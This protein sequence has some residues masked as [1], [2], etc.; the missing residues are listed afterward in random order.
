MTC[1]QA[2]L[3]SMK[4]QT[5][6]AVVAVSIFPAGC[7][8]KSGSSGASSS[9]G[10]EQAGAASAAITAWEQG[11]KST[12]ISSFVGA[13]WTARPLFSSSSASSLS[14]AQFRALPEAARQAKSNGML[15][16]LDVLK[17]LA[18]AAVLAGHTLQPTALVHE[19]YLRLVGPEQRKSRSRRHSVA[20]AAEAMRHILIEVLGE[21]SDAAV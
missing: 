4:T 8:T 5:M 13:D 6:S 1:C 20:V 7:G 9:P 16:Q 21:G 14:E 11:D 10:K 3:Q 17:Q 12:A 15:A 18:A 2:A 19:A